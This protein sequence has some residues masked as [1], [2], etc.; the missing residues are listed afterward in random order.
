M[1]CTP[2]I[3]IAA[4]RRAAVRGEPAFAALSRDLWQQLFEEFPR[5]YGRT[6]H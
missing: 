5:S 4:R 3:S 2:T 1:L 6:D